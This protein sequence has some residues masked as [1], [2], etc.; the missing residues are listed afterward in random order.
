MPNPA[1]VI[2]HAFIACLIALSTIVSVQLIG[3]KASTMFIAV[4]NSLK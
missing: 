1:D 3:T 2:E 4:G